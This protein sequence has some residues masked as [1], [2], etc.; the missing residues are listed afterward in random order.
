M[1]ENASM[2]TKKIHCQAMALIFLGLLLSQSLAHAGLIIC[3]GNNGHLAVE[4]YQHC[5]SPVI[6][7]DGLFFIEDSTL[8]YECHPCT[9]IEILNSWGMNDNSAMAPISS[10]FSPI[11][12]IVSDLC[13]Q[14]LGIDLDHLFDSPHLTNRFSIMVFRI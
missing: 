3:R 13:L 12:F 14:S 2:K 4:I 11:T 10:A 7:E 1:A 6:N 9:D 5:Q 8:Q